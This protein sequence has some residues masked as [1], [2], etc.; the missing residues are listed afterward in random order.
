MNK[1][2]LETSQRFLNNNRKWQIIQVWLPGASKFGSWKRENE[3]KHEIVGWEKVERWTVPDAEYK[4]VFLM[5]FALKKRRKFVEDFH[6]LIRN[7]IIGL[8]V[9]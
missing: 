9:Y 1:K 7:Q 6:I 2:G 4:C 8:S 3:Q 5:N